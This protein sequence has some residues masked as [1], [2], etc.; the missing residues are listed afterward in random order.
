MRERMLYSFNPIQSCKACNVCDGAAKR[1]MPFALGFPSTNSRTPKQQNSG[2][3]I[4]ISNSGHQYLHLSGVVN[5]F[6]RMNKKS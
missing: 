5:D 6:K 3:S 4:P 1:Q 2:V